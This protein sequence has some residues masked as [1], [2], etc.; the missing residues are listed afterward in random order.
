MFNDLKDLLFLQ[1]IGRSFKKSLRKL[2]SR[3]IT[4]YNVKIA[5]IAYKNLAKRYGMS[6]REVYSYLPLKIK[7]DPELEGAYGLCSRYIQE[8]KSFFTKKITKSVKSTISL[9][10]KDVTT[11]TFIHEFGHYLRF[12]I[13][14]IARSKNK[15]AYD[16][17]LKVVDLVRSRADAAQKEYEHYFSRGGFTVDE[18]ENFAK[19]WEQYMK[20]GIAPSK[21]YRHLFN[22]FRKAIFDDM[23]KRNE[24]RKYEF[25]ED[26]EV[27]ITPERKSFFDTIILGK[28]FKKKSKIVSFIEC[29]TYILVFILIFHYIYNFI[30][31]IGIINL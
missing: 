20:D 16:D 6:A 26:L 25:Y 17:F 11:T 5:K 29:Y 30:S 3:K 10:K 2:Y 4:K 7:I 23:H 13:E 1:K 15:K 19:S 18:E 14:Q 12:L 8:K 9:N 21:T 24:K 31:R 22:H 27:K 28:R